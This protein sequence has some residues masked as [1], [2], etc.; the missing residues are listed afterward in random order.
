MNAI[1]MNLQLNFSNKHIF[2]T[3]ETAKNTSFTVKK[4]VQGA[5]L[6]AAP[7]NRKYAFE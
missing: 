5:A 3:N 7:D 1:I 2:K 4:K 6:K